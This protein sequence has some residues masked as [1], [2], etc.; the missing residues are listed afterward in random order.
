MTDKKSTT[1]LAHEAQA[2]KAFAK[3][4]DEDQRKGVVFA[5]EAKRTASNTAKTAKLRALREASEV[6]TEPEPKGGK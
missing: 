1:Q 4:K 3:T 5:E 2:N 6:A